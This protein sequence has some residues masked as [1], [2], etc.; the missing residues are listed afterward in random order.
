MS[1][2]KLCDK[3]YISNIYNTSTSINKLKFKTVNNTNNN[4]I[5][6]AMFEAVNNNFIIDNTWHSITPYNDKYQFN[7]TSKIV[8]KNMTK[9]YIEQCHMHTVTKTNKSHKSQ[10]FLQHAN[11]MVIIIIYK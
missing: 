2:Y 3:C 4:E 7:V 11:R 5:L 8:T 10:G 1:Q 9:I 6:N